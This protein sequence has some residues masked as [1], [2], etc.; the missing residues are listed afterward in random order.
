MPATLL[1]P[2]AVEPWTVADAKNFLRVEHD[3]DDA[4][5]AGLIASARGQVEAL[6]RRGLI[7]Q[8][9][10][11]VLDRWPRDG[12]LAP[13][14]AP[15]RA[16]MAARVYDAVGDA[17]TLDVE[18]FV[19]DPVASTIAAPGWSLPMP[20]RDVGGIELDVVVGFGDDAADVP[21]VLRHAVRTLV[22]HWYDNRGLAAIGA[23]VAMLPG[24]VSA[25]IASYRVLSL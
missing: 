11:L 22:A 23:S 3:D 19:V 21:D 9:W 5:I 24:S 15:L 13:R 2:A 16:V 25:M 4:V 8:T 1:V 10:R 14:L 7:T 20:G 12:R 17:M 6:T 18:R